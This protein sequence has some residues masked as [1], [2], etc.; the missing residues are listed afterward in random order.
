MQE[1]LEVFIFVV[2]AATLVVGWALLYPTDE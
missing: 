2:A 1:A